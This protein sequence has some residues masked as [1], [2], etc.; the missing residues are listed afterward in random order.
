MIIKLRNIAVENAYLLDTHAGLCE[1]FYEC[2][3]GV[4]AHRE[5]DA[6][7]RKLRESYGLPALPPTVHSHKE[8]VIEIQTLMKSTGFR[9][10]MDEIKGVKAERKA[11]EEKKMA[12]EEKEAAKKK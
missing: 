6:Q 5:A 4:P 12:E 1:R 7:W 2:G 9:Q 8:A 10:L 3:H 11:E